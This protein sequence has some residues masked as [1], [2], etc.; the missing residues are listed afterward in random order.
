MEKRAMSKSGKS[1]SNPIAQ[2]SKV[3]F[4]V[5][6]LYVLLE[7]SRL[8][9]YQNALQSASREAVRYGSATGEGEN[10]VPRYQDC[11]GIRAA[12]QK[13]TKLITLSDDDI[14]IKHDTG[15]N[16]PEVIYCSSELTADLS[17]LP[18]KGTNHQ[19][20]VIIEKQYT[21]LLP[22]ITKTISVSTQVTA[23]PTTIESTTSVNTTIA[24][25][26]ASID[27]ALKQTLSASIAYNAPQSIKLDDTVTISLLL[28]PSETPEG[29]ATQVTEP[30][31]VVTNS[32]EVTPRMKAVL[33]SQ[34]DGDF[35]IKEIHDS[36]EQ[37]ISAIETT[38]WSWYVTA[39]REGV[40]KLTLVIY[41][42]VTV[43][44]QEYWRQVEAYKSDINVQ[45]TFVQQLSQFDWK[46]II[47]ILLTAILIPAF[48]RWMDGRKKKEELA[49]VEKE[50]A[51]PQRKA[52][53]KKTK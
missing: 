10:G 29:L 23:V 33:L 25:Q 21:P 20:S 1:H 16:T 5:L 46:W 31:Q 2:L 3:L 50:K 4:F 47:G 6:S 22:F 24:Q 41:R 32:I 34:S 17:Y 45:V 42:L 15:P 37:V 35:L 48:W 14:L 51:K 28:N 12:A 40:H 39:K 38:Q 43:D 11:A 49:K 36:P 52:N 8:F 30:G 44:G 26:L 27:S 18:D 13:F 7:L 53:N 9:F 19:I